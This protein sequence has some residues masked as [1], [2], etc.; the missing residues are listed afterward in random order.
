[1]SFNC[2]NTGSFSHTLQKENRHRIKKLL[3]QGHTQYQ[4]HSPKWSLAQSSSPA[5]MGDVYPQTENGPRRDSRSPSETTTASVMG[6]KLGVRASTRRASDSQL[7]SYQKAFFS[8]V[9]TRAPNEGSDHTP[10]SPGH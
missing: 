6:Q 7:K 5:D 10:R 9:D 3:A 4:W 8:T 1:M 2:N